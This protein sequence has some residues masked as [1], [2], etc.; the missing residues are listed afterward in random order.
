MAEITSNIFTVHTPLQHLIV[1][2][3]VE[4]MGQFRDS[5]NFLVLD[6]PAEKI[7]P[8][9]KNWRDIL[10]LNPPVGRYFI[11]NGKNCRRA[12]KFIEQLVSPFKN[13][14]LFVSDI[15]WPLNNAIYGM[16]KRYP[17]ENIIVSNFPDGL[18]SLVVRHPRLKRKLRSLAKF[19]I[20]LLGGLPYHFYKGDIMGLEACD[21]VYTLL[22]EVLPAG[23]NPNLIPIPPF[24]IAAEKTLPDTCIFLGQSYEYIFPAKE[25]VR[26]CT[27]AADYVKSLGYAKNFYKPHHFSKTDTEKQIFADR[28]F[29]LFDDPRPI[30]EYFFTVQIACVASYNSSALVHLKLMFGDQVRCISCLSDWSSKHTIAGKTSIETI[31]NLFRVCGVEIYD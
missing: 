28:G 7:S 22:P 24:N 3:M 8:N 4:E 5:S 17:G 31:R 18:G 21:R 6:M 1:N 26:F 19:I 9:R 2:H 13:T 27:K 23:L 29:E 11:G 30:E 20:G 10:Y 15:E 16:A 25:H 14:A 12:I